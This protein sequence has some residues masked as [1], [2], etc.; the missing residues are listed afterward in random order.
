MGWCS[1]S[2]RNYK[3]EETPKH[4]LFECGKFSEQREEFY[5]DLTELLHRD[6]PFSV[7]T[8]LGENPKLSEVKTKKL[9]SIFED[10]CESTGRFAPNDQNPHDPD[11]EIDGFEDEDDEKVFYDQ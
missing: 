10:Y 11:L 2:S 5:R 7:C 9:Y 6:P 1:C 4:F 3:V 8:F